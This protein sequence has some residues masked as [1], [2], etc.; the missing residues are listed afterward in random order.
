MKSRLHWVERISTSL[1]GSRHFIILSIFLLSDKALEKGF[2][3]HWETRTGVFGRGNLG[4]KEQGKQKTLLYGIELGQKEISSILYAFDLTIF[5]V[6]K[7]PL[8]GWR[9]GKR[10]EDEPKITQTTSSYSI[11]QAFFP[12][13]ETSSVTCAWP[14]TLVLVA[15]DVRGALGKR[16]RNCGIY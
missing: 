9:Y 13:F 11:F 2:K 15:W 8:M 7:L 1:F 10:S 4:A 5:C 3:H 16:R 14:P 6:H 12:S